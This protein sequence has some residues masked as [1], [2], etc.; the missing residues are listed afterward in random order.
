[1][2]KVNQNRSQLSVG[3]AHFFFFFRAT[4]ASSLARIDGELTDAA[5]ARKRD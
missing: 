5:A 4:M 3:P 1:M 2:C